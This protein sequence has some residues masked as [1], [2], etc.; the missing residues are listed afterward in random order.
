MGG[1][2]GGNDGIP[3]SSADSASVFDTSLGCGCCCDALPAL[4]LGV[5]SASV[6]AGMHASDTQPADLF[7]ADT[8]A[9]GLPPDE[10]DEDQARFQDGLGV[11]GDL[12]ISCGQTSWDMASS[13]FRLFPVP[14]NGGSVPGHQAATRIRDRTASDHGV[15]FSFS[16]GSFERL[17][18]SFD[19]AGH[20]LLVEDERDEALVV[21]ASGEVR[22]RRCCRL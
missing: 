7:A 1:G 5:R 8:A 16:G 10:E 6:F 12:T 14:P 11:G 20:G 18:Q 19:D 15:T 4:G 2:G 13:S 22:H 17:G 9:L 21:F 3:T